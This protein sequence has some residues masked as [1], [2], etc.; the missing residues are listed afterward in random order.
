MAHSLLVAAEARQANATPSDDLF[1]DSDEVEIARATA[2]LDELDRGADDD[3]EL[4][5]DSAAL[6]TSAYDLLE[7]H[8]ED[9]TSRIV[10]P[11]H[12]RLTD[13]PIS[14][15]IHLINLAMNRCAAHTLDL[16]AKTDTDLSR[17]DTKE[18][19]KKIFTPGMGE[20]NSILEQN[21]PIN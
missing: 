16:I 13:Q 15:V 8:A 3:H 14:V 9:V 18:F 21:W 6:T 4:I 1:D 17:F 19:Q 12:L 5:K 10:L 11:D 2:M 20:N 7:Q